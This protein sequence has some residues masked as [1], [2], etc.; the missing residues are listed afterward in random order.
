MYII[1]TLH[2]N[3][4]YDFHR[5]QI[6]VVSVFDMGVMKISLTKINASVSGFN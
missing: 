4:Y 6:F 1:I 3:N 2:D 5:V